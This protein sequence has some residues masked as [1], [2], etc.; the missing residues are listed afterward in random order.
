MP[1]VA[2]PPSPL[3]RRAVTLVALAAAALGVGLAGVRLFGSASLSQPLQLVTSGWEQQ[4]LFDIWR[5]VQ[6]LDLYVDATRIPY[7]SA[8]Y[9]WLFYAV[10]GTWTQTGLQALGLSE[11]WL[12]TVGRSLTLL[13]VPIGIVVAAAGLQRLGGGG[14]GGARGVVLAFAVSL[15]TGPLVGFWIFTLRP[16]LWAMVLEMLA[17]LAFWRLWSERPRWAIG[18][19]VAVCYLAWGFKHSNL[20]AAAT[21]G[22]FLLSERRFAAAAAFASLMAVAFAVTFALS[23][24][25]YLP[26]IAGVLLQAVPETGLRNLANFSVKALPQLLPLAVL[27]WALLRVPALRRAALA[28]REWRFAMI[29]AS[30]TLAMS[31]VGAVKEGAA[32]NYYFV[33]SFFTAA[34]ALAGWRLAEAAGHRVG[35]RVDLWVRGAM[36]GGWLLHGLAI[37]GVL[38]GVRGVTSNMELHGNTVAA[39]PCLNTLPQPVLTQEQYLQ[40][41]WMNPARPVFFPSYNYDLNRAAGVDFEGGGLG[42][43]VDDGYFGALLVWSPTEDLYGGKVARHYDL[44]PELCGKR[45]VYRRRSGSVP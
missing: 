30:V 24:P 36:L 12:P 1:P 35:H 18:V 39:R 34:A 43:L 42:K 31:V 6:G 37:A 2:A 3:S 26:S 28:D 44:D 11:D 27:V 14:G 23:S 17:V 32:E 22:V 13:A 8:F 10:Y 33:A 25:W 9:N 20:F 7:Y 16:D 15:M 4:T 38:V 45:S 21:V 40:L 19:A 41:P 29:G 5:Y